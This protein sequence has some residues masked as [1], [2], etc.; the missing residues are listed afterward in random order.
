MEVYTSDS[1]DSD[2]H[3]QKTLDY[4]R[5]G[6][7]SECLEEN[8][9]HLHKISKLTDIETVLLNHNMITTLPSQTLSHFNNLHVLDLSSNGLT[10]LP[11]NLLQIC[12]LLT[13][14]ILKN[15]LLTNSSLPK[16]FK[17]SIKQSGLRELNLSGNLLT[18]FPDAVLELNN[19][20]Y[21]Y[22]GANKIT[23]ISKEI[24]R[25]QSLNVLSLGGNLIADVPDTVGNLQQLQALTLCDNLIEILPANIARLTNLKSLL[26]HKNRLR[27]L[28]RDIITLK[29]LVELSLREN[30]L[31]VRFVQEIS[32][33]PPSLLELS[34]RVI[35]TASV[36]FEPHELPKSMTDY[37]NTAHCCVNPKCKGV[38]FDNRIEHIK[39]VDFCGKYRIPLLQYLCSSKCIEGVN[40]NTEPQPSSSSSASGIMMRKVLLG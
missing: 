17:S 24:W 11:A 34:A 37:L 18:H 4:G 25:L 12:P 16:C 8:L 9:S 10:Q 5:L 2:S 15:N 14:L 21:L 26:L 19:L 29:N 1:S 33:H 27:H 3:E 36:P 7:T 31:V 39:F 22:L 35:R 23:S 28:P 20:K 40:R 30:P 13:K 32:L 6:L 38:F